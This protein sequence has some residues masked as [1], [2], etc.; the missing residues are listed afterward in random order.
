MG[1]ST[2]HKHV[3]SQ[4]TAAVEWNIIHNLRTLA[5]IVDVMIDTGNGLQKIIPLDTVVVDQNTVKVT[6]SS[7]RT[8]KASVI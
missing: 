3:H 4:T 5:P 6:F 8:G 1:V 2:A 7:A